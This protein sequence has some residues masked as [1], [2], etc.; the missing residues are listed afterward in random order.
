MSTNLKSLRKIEPHFNEARVRQAV[1]HYFDS[2]PEVLMI[3][4]FNDQL[5]VVAVAYNNGRYYVYNYYPGRTELANTTSYPGNKVT[6]QE[7]ADSSM[8]S[9]KRLFE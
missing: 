1:A 6:A 7:A 5:L 8:A 2:K 3:E 9:L 4:R